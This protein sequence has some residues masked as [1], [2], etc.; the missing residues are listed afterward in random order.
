MLLRN[1]NCIHIDSVREP[2]LLVRD[3][4]IV[5]AHLALPHQ[6][7]ICKGPILKAVSSPPLARL[8]VPFIPKLHSDLASELAL[9][10]SHNIDIYQLEAHTLLSVKANNSFLR[11]YPSSLDHLSLRNSTISSRP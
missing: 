9:E 5:P 2:S 4:D 1:F 3:L 7:I 11:R 10:N 8:V 6:P